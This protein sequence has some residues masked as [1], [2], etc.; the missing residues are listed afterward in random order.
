MATKHSNRRESRGPTLG[1]TLVETAVVVAVLAIAAATAVPSLADFIELRRLDAAA[2]QLAADLQLARSESLARNRALRLSVQ[3][4]S[5]ASCW[6]VHTGLA[7]DCRCGA[8]PD[9]AV[10]NAGTVAVKTVTLGGTGRLRV[11]ANVASMRFEPLHGTV[12][13]AGTLR[14]VDSRGRAVQHVVN[15]IG[16]PRSCSPSGAVNGWR[17]C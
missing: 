7:A 17:A 10:C 15:V 2:N 5:D 1:L 9:T 8:A 6:I 12:T 4:A 14:V 3:A 13:P 11:E 16:R